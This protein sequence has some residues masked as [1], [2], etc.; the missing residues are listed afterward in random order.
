MFTVAVIVV[1]L[2]LRVKKSSVPIC[3]LYREGLDKVNPVV[4]PIFRFG[5]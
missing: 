5:S 4:T 3:K 1:L 2:V